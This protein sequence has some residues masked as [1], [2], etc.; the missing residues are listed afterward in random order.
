MQFRNITLATVFRKNCKTWRKNED[1]RTDLV[2]QYQIMLITLGDGNK[3]LWKRRNWSD[4][5]EVKSIGLSH[6]QRV[7]YEEPEME[8]R[9]LLGQEKNGSGV[10][11]HQ[12]REHQ[13]KWVWLGGDE[14]SLGQPRLQFLRDPR[15]HTP[16]DTWAASVDLYDSTRGIPRAP[17]CPSKTHQERPRHPDFLSAPAAIS[18]SWLVAISLL[19]SSSW[20]CASSPMPVSHNT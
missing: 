18:L 9:L 7:R 5:L 12:G 13:R 2:N 1:E 11:M 19:C 16:R 15:P 4:I 20:S 10:N 8:S 17:G 14:C 6:W 3:G